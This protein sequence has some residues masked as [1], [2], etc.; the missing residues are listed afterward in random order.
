MKLFIVT[1][2]FALAGMA[3]ADWQFSQPVEAGSVNKKTLFHH[4]ESSNRKGLAES[5]GRVALV[6]EDNRDGAPRC[7]LAVR[8][9]GENSFS[10]PQAISKGE[11]YEPVVEGMAK[12]HFALAWEEDGATWVK[13]A[14]KGGALKLSQQEAAQV[15]LAS[16]DSQTLY[17]AW[18]EQAGQFRRI[19]IARLT[20]ING[21]LGI[22]YAVPLEDRLPSDDQAYPALA[23]NAA[24]SVAAVWEDRRFKHTVMLAAHSQDGRN[25]ALPYRLIDVPQARARTLGAGMGSM[26]PTLASC[27]PACLV[28]L[29][30]DKR[31]FLS[32]YDVY[33]AL[34]QNGGKFFG[35]NLKVQDSFG[36]NIAQWHASVSANRG[37]RVVAAWDD[38][39]DGTSDVWLSNWTGNGFSDNFSVPGASGPGMQTEPVIHLDETGTLHLAWLERTE[40]GGTRLKYVNAVWKE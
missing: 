12:G 24:G 8:E 11:C 4:L 33:A 25:F 22:E 23:V 28:A 3:H 34:S 5:G 32:G 16:A 29:W 14:G 40:H 19:M 21:S 30:L 26:R 31:D 10:P 13:L 36:E 18:A 17:A 15:T 20:V 38:D 35:R 1:L 9:Q 6:W 37:G 39:R 7:W 2:L 27:G